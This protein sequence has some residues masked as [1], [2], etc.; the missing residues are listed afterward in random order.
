M[1]R[2]RS[3]ARRGRNETRP[4]MVHRHGRC[5]RDSNLAFNLTW[6]DRLNLRSLC[7]VSEVITQAGIPR[8]NSR[9]AHFRE[10]FPKSG[11]IEGSDFTV[12]TKTADGIKMTRKPV[13]FTI[14]HPGVTILPDDALVTLVAEPCWGITKAPKRTCAPCAVTLA[15]RVDSSRCA[16]EPPMQ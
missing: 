4:F 5:I 16:M 6:R 3:H 14:I 2:R 9:G 11:G 12:A 15:Y 7:G 8:E 1:E 13:Q 10:N